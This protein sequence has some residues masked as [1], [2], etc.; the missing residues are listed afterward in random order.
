MPLYEFL[1]SHCQAS[2]ER[3]MSFSVAQSVV[4]P[5]CGSQQTQRQLGLP[6]IHFKG[7]GFYRTDSRAEAEERQKKAKAET[8]SG[9]K[10]ESGD[11]SQSDRNGN[12]DASGT[13]ERDSSRAEGTGDVQKGPVEA[14]GARKASS[15][16]DNA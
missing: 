14:S 7:G 12:Q 8:G 9:D 13:A 4:C 11:K 1:C 5:E 16:S 2:F 6:A 10:S 15:D 3:L